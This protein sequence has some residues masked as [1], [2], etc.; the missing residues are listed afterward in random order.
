M[1]F[2][3]QAGRQSVNSPALTA[4]S[5]PDGLAQPVRLQPEKRRE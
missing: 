1:V 2:V 4:V 5:G 3:L